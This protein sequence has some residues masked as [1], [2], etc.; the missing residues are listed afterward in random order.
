LLDVPLL[1]RRVP[2]FPAWPR[3]RGRTSS[4]HTP[5]RDLTWEELGGGYGTRCA[6]TTCKA[7][8]T[9]PSRAPAAASGL[10][11][12]PAP[13]TRPLTAALLQGRYPRKVPQTR[14]EERFGGVRAAAGRQEMSLLASISSSHKLSSHAPD[15]FQYLQ[16]CPWHCLVVRLRLLRERSFSHILSA[17]SDAGQGSGP[18]TRV[19]LFPIP[20]GAASQLHV[21][22]QLTFLT[23]TQNFCRFL[24]PAATPLPI[25]YRPKCPC[26]FL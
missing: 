19:T 25:K 15:R 16:L 4:C 23:P 26:H 1:L 11:H 9:S 14:Q 12:T 7:L 13:A 18:C 3:R 22:L 20:V 5:A 2:I 24:Y 8:T 21:H 10:R 6:Q 17:L